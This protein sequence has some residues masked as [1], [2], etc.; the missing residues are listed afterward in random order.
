MLQFAG[1]RILEIPPSNYKD[2]DI[3][4]RYDEHADYWYGTALSQ[5]PNKRMRKEMFCF[6]GPDKET[7][8]N[9]IKEFLNKRR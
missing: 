3:S 9:N 4:I 2:F 1:R 6:E 5:M 7:V 8:W